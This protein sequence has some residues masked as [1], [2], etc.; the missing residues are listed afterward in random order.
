MV[1]EMPPK[2]PKSAYSDTISKAWCHI[3]AIFID[4]WGPTNLQPLWLQQ[5]STMDVE[6]M[7]NKWKDKWTPR[8]SELWTD[9]TEQNTGVLQH[10]LV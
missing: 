2:P 7:E 9:G 1:E 6:K 10:Y 4:D 8:H 5:A 3:L